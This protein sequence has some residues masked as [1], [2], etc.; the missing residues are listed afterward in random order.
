MKRDECASYGGRL[1]GE[2]ID[3]W[4]YI[5]VNITLNNRA[6]NARDVLTVL[7]VQ[8]NVI[9]PPPES[10]YANCGER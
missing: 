3:V 7:V 5:I 6:F 2:I 8:N 4:A 9:H 10:V 1:K